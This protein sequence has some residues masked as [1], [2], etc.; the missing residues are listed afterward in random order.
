MICYVLN[1]TFVKKTESLQPVLDNEVLIRQW[2]LPLDFSWSLQFDCIIYVEHNA[3]NMD[4]I[5]YSPWW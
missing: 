3:Q 5:W 2:S 4:V 1:G